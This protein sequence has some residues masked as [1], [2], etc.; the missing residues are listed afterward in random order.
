[1][2]IEFYKEF[3]EYG[4]LANYSNHGFTVN[5]VFYPT[6]E[7]FYQASKFDDPMI[8]Q[9]ILACKTPKEASVIGR[10][11]NLTRIPHFRDIKLDKMYQGVY[12]KFLQNPDI[13]KK[14]LDTGDEEIKEMTVKESFWGV[15]PHFDGENHMGKILMKVRQQLRDEK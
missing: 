6:A 10:D 13:Q 3:G 8:I 5:G 14:L 9:R 7:H 2:A 15:G 4:Y 12:E 1:M 11:R